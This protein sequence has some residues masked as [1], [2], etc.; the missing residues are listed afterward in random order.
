MKRRDFLRNSVVAALGGASIYSVQGNLRLLQAVANG[1]G[2]NTFD[3]Y[4]ALVCVF[5]YGGNDSLNMVVP[6]DG[7]AHAQYATAR[8]TL[9]LPQEALIPLLPQAGGEPSDGANYG[10]MAAID[11]VD[12]VGMSGLQGLFNNGNA[13]ILGNVGTLVAPVTKSDYENG[14]ATLPPQLF[15]HEDQQ[16]YWQ[17]SRSDDARNLGWGGRIAD[18]LL[19]ANPGA[20]IP[21]AISID[22]ETI[23]SRAAITSQYVCGAY[24]PQS[25]NHFWHD[26]R[27]KAA[28]NLLYRRQAHAMERGYA[29]AFNRAYDNTLSL[30]NALEG[31]PA[32]STPF[33]GTWL[34]SQL[35]MVARLISVRDIIRH[36]RQIFFVAIGGFD[37]HDNQLADHPV[38]LADL[39][40]SL[41][42]FHAATTE[43]GVADS[44]TAFSASDFGRT[45]SSNGDGSDHGWGSHQFVVGDAVRGG[46]FYGTMP[47]LENNGPDDAGW[48]QIIP[49]TSVDQYAA[50]LA[51]WFG[52]ADPELDVIFPNLGNFAS[53]DLG[54]ML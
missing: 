40:Q 20:S 16:S 3:D 10:L 54:F 5:M 15:S 18:L 44:V 53:R 45:L 32:P 17:M 38:I 19:D 27:R 6:R 33:P 4:K 1:Y 23:L 13:A 35:A 22:S 43:L 48:G 52:I 11:D 37:T 2:P 14:T 34:G 41:T 25:Y 42:A 9:A 8:A 49:T 7:A 39:A 28:F 46:R 50:T 30:I 26:E 36:K 51:R 21:M 47:V 29:T 31:T 24:G 12:P